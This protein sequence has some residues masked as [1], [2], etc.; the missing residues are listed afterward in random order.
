MHLTKIHRPTILANEL[1]PCFLYLKI[2]NVKNVLVQLIVLHKKCM[3]L[4]QIL[5]RSKKLILMKENCLLFHIVI[6]KRFVS[7]CRP[8][9][10][11]ELIL[12][13]IG[14]LH[15][16]LAIVL[17]DKFFKRIK[18]RTWNFAACKIRGKRY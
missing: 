14:P 18:I 10:G 3:G 8:D 9:V 15:T 1:L 2:S 7:T 17:L 4:L 5:N 12:T 6:E 16:L 13:A 11:H